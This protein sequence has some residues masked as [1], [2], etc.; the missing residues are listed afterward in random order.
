MLKG[1]EEKKEIRGY[2]YER[3]GVKKGRTLGLEELGRKKDGKRLSYDYMTYP[4]SVD[5][6]LPL[7]RHS[8]FP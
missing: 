6:T 5:V 2:N 8:Q 7:Q 1:L 3:R 4:Y